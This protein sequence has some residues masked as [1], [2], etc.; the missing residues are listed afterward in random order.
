MGVGW[1][2]EYERN[3]Y[4]PGTDADG[5]MVCQAEGIKMHLSIASRRAQRIV[6]RNTD[7]N[8]LR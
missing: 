4:T 7:F 2:Y 3:E 8:L 1:F 5:L 6:T